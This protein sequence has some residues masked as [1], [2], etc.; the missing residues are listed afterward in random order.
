YVETVG[1]NQ[2]GEAVL[3]FYRWVMV[4]KREG[5]GALADPQVP[6][7]PKALSAGEL[8]APEGL[9]FSKLD[10][11]LTGGAHFWEDYRPGERI[12]HVD[13]TTIEEAEHQL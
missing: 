7:L 4:N 11:Q 8:V 6:E 10:P 3:R 1:R 2:V 12:D 13:G 5:A 9:E